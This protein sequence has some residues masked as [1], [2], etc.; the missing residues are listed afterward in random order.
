[1]MKTPQ[2]IAQAWLDAY[3]RRDA[4]ALIELYADDARNIQ[5]AFGDEPLTGR[6]ALLEN[7]TA[8]FRAFPDNFTNP[9]NIFVDGDWAIIEWRG[10]GTFTGALG[11]FAPTGKSFELSGCGFLQVADGKIIFQRGYIDKQTWFDQIGVVPGRA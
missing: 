7:F 8:F 6:A 2:E 11:E 1:M 4:D 5:V 10:G 3:N 9:V